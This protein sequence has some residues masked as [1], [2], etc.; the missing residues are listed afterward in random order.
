MQ[1]IIERHC[2][3]MIDGMSH[4]QSAILN[5]PAP[6]R[7]FSAPTGAGK[8]YAF[9]EMVQ[10]LR[11]RVL[12][13][14]PTKR[15]A[16]NL[17][18]TLFECLLE[19]GVSADEAK[20]RVALW[21]SDERERLEDQGIKVGHL[22]VRQFRGHTAGERGDMIIATPESVAAYMLRPPHVSGVSSAGIWDLPSFDHVVFD[23]FHTTDPRGF[24]LAAAVATFAAGIK[25]GFKVTFLS[26]TPIEIAP[27]LKAFGV[28]AD[29]MS[30]R[31]EDVV[32]GPKS[33]TGNARA[34][35]GDMRIVFDGDADVVRIFEREK[36]ALLQC[37]SSG[38]QVVVIFDSIADLMKAKAR[39]AKACD[40]V[41]VVREERLAINSSDDS[42]FGGE[43]GALF[44]EGR[45][46]NPLDYKVLI[47]TSSVEMGVTFR[48]GLMI[49]DRGFSAM[50]FL[51]RVG[52]PARGD[53]EGTVF[54]STG[55]NTGSV[56]WLRLAMKRLEGVDRIDIA[57]FIAAFAGEKTK[58]M[59]E[60]VETGDQV[61]FGTLPTR[62]VRIAGLFWV[63][64]TNSWNASSRGHKQTLQEFE[65]Q[66]VT[67]VLHG[68]IRALKRLNLGNASRWADAFL[69][70]AL[71]LRTFQPTVTLKEPSGKTRTLS[72]SLF[73]ATSYLV[74]CPASFCEDGRL[75]VELDIPFDD[76]PEL[77]DRRHVSTISLM[78]P[79][80]QGALQVNSKSG[81]SDWQRYVER[82]LD[83]NC[84]YQEERALS[85]ALDLVK[86][87]GIVPPADIEPDG[88]SEVS[89]L[90]RPPLA[91]RQRDNWAKRRREV[92]VVRAGKHGGA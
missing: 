41:G 53:E 29:K 76:I 72:S 73:A 83:G 35:H 20:K 18:M 87:T 67:K 56:P 55:N 32:T 61:T 3:P 57:S 62:S 74:G 2:V 69:A 47:C 6:I 38:R 85:I 84:A 51:Q 86:M 31:S 5:D 49:M 52:R 54:V 21:T 9:L 78:L 11:Q 19:N 36:D 23:E 71:V 27:T 7:I 81:V 68:K 79:T 15:L 45:D 25:N 92:E 60:G 63:A 39:I 77:R 13:I 8:S 46:K 50:S 90:D 42:A 65:P 89:T 40:A 34:V 70:Q 10:N 17:A 59:S 37:L 91:R 80:G 33:V 75:V 30:I 48:A 58:K 44:V 82:M 12:F 66:K 43:G 16:Q 24:G 26:A 4:L 64:M 1:V 14:V 88:L 22:R 28:P